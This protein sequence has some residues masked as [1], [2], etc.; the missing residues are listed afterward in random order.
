DARLALGA[1]HEQL[2]VTGQLQGAAG[3]PALAATRFP[4]DGGSFSRTAF[5]YVPELNLYLGLRLLD[6]VTVRAGYTAV[7]WSAVGRAADQ[8]NLQTPGTSARIEVIRERGL[9][10]HGLDLALQVSF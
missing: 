6:N 10:V 1:V 2:N 3:V 4:A 8:I 9:F 7:Y 5:S